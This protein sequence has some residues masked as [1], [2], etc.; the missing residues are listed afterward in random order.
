MLTDYKSIQGWFDYE[1]VFDQCIDQLSQKLQR[2]LVVVEI[3]AW[4]GKSSH[5][6]VDRHS[7]KCDI[8]IV[9]TWQGS[10]DEMETNHKLADERDI[11][12]DF[13]KNMKIHYGKFTPIR[14]LST[15]AANIFEDHSVDFIFI[16]GDHSYHGVKSDIK[17]WLPKLAIQGIIAGHDYSGS[18]PGVVVAVNEKFGHENIKVQRISW[19]Y[20]Q[21]DN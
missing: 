12:V 14:A 2:P 4:L 17:A 3:G 6:L 13:M 16:D 15:D 19:I 21:K 20:E 9:D 18:F 7:E 1:D 10:D 5:Y 11:F 8:F